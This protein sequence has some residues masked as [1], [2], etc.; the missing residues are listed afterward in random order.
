MRV[1]AIT[2]DLDDTLWAIDPVIVRAE[3]LL[4]AW[5][6]E[7]WPEIA[8]RFPPPE[9][10]ALRERLARRHPHLHHDLSATR[11]LAL[12]H[13]AQA[14]GY[15]AE[16]AD[17]AFDVLWKARNQ[18]ELYP[19]VLPTLQALA[20]H[21][22]LA[23]LTNGNADIGLCGVGHLLRFCVSAREVGV[24]KPSPEI[25]AHAVERLGVAPHE[26]LHV[27]DDPRSDVGGARK[28]GMRTV[29]VNRVGAPWPGGPQADRE[30]RG[31]DALVDW[32][33]RQEETPSATT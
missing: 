18:V 11:R 25:F 26:V 7:H 1:R 14:C 5:F 19:D 29:W 6:G 13:A 23:G 17:A 30:V 16:V 27:G 10:R 3:E 12:A 32:L 9:L 28:A 4:H 8:R 20:E 15:G 24:P 33:V 21:Y 2:F 22:P 31:L